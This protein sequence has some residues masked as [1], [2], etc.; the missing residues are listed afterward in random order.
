MVSILVILLQGGVSTTILDSHYT[1]EFTGTYDEHASR[2][3]LV[4]CHV[5]VCYVP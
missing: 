5:S 2:H 3:V 4:I 1:E